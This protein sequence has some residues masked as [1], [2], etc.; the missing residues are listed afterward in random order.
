MIQY[1]RRTVVKAVIYRVFMIVITVV[2][3]FLVTRQAGDALTIGL[4]SNA[5][6]TATYYG[7]DRL[8][9]RITWGLQYNEN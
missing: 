1:Q 8:W 7:Y 4:W 3:A 2:F 5:V 6:K 9:N